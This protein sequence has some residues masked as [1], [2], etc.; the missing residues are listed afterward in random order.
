MANA[1]VSNYRNTGKEHFMRIRLLFVAMVLALGVTAFADTNATGVMTSHTSNAIVGTTAGVFG[2]GLDGGMVGS[3]LRKMGSV[4]VQFT[5]DT[6]YVDILF[7]QYNVDT[8]AVTQVALSSLSASSNALVA[9]NLLAADPT[10][11]VKGSAAGT[12]DNLGGGRYKVT[13][14][15]VGGA[16]SDAAPQGKN[17]WV[18]G[19]PSAPIALQFVMKNAAINALAGKEYDVAIVAGNPVNAN[20][21]YRTTKLAGAAVAFDLSGGKFKVVPEPG[22]IFAIIAGLGGLV[23]LRR[24]K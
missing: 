23:G 11:V 16:T 4:Q 15:L 8:G 2:I 17:P 13:L 18:T 6:N 20:S 12:A 1:S 10:V 7:G 9:N 22:S 3:T 21:Y 14:G 5:I 24:R 19:D